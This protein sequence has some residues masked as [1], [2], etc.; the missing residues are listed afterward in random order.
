MKVILL[1]ILT[2]AKRDSM[3][4][5]NIR[6]KYFLNTLKFWIQMISCQLVTLLFTTLAFKTILQEGYEDFLN[7]ENVCYVCN[8]QLLTSVK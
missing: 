5:L 3:S 4:G 1:S 8:L 6:V 7:L 2:S